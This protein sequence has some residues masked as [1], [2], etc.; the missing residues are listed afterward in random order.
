MVA[1]AARMV[2]L[3]PVAVPMTVAVAVVVAPEAVRVRPQDPLHRDV[4]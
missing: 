1:V 3:V 2:V 4:G